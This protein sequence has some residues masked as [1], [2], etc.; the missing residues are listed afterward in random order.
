MITFIDIKRKP[1]DIIS[2]QTVEKVFPIKQFSSDSL[3]HRMSSTAVSSLGHKLCVMQKPLWVMLKMMKPAKNSTSGTFIVL[4]YVLHCTG[5]FFWIGGLENLGHQSGCSFFKFYDHFVTLWLHY[6]QHD[7]YVFRKK[8]CFSFI[9]VNKWY[10]PF[11][12]S[13]VFFYLC[14][15]IWQYIHKLLQ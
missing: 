6:F 10:T 2:E 8:T 12:S 15:T 4:W 5:H 13:C 3:L 7:P 11:F 9:F 14:N 1:L